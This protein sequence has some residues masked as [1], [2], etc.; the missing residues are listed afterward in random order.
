MP[1]KHKKDNRRYSKKRDDITT[2]ELLDTTVKVGL[3]GVTVGLVDK[4]K[5]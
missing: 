1:C 4:M 5:R 3:L 2:K